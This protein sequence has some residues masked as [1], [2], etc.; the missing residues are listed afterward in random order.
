VMLLRNCTPKSCRTCPF[1]IKSLNGAAAFGRNGAAS[2]ISLDTRK[3]LSR[4]VLV[5]VAEMP[6]RGSQVVIAERP[7][8]SFLR[9]ESA[10]FITLKPVDP[11]RAGIDDWQTVVVPQIA[12]C[13]MNE[14]VDEIKGS[15]LGNPFEIKFEIVEKL[16]MSSLH[17]GLRALRAV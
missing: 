11:L 1:A 17:A 5:T 10:G 15:V 4:L 7:D 13:V 14:L 16:A 12:L 2:H 9:A 8:I 6:V 3:L